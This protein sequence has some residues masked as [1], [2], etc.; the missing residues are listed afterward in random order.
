MAAR[1]PL[2]LSVGERER[3]A[4]AAVLVASPR[5]LVLDEPTRGMD[6]ER[7]ATLAALLRERARAGAAV[8]VA[9]HDA[10]FAAAACGRRLAM[11]ELGG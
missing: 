9:T 7:K 5:V 3:V 4:L 2:E 11:G 10:A 8:L 1:H 6:P